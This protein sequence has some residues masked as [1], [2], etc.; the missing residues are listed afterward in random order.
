MERRE[1]ER[2]VPSGGRK[3]PGV[4]GLKGPVGLGHGESGAEQRGPQGPLRPSQ[5]QEEF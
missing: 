5:P 2:S 1:G 3:G 4:W